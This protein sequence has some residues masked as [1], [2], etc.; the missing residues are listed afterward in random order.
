MK[1]PSVYYPLPFI[2][3]LYLSTLHSLVDLCSETGGVYVLPIKLKKF[4]MSIN[5]DQLTL[6]IGFLFLQTINLQFLSVPK[7]SY[8]LYVYILYIY[9]EIKEF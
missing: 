4:S 2:T 1:T 9:L 8:I 5:L 6:I 3:Y 7:N